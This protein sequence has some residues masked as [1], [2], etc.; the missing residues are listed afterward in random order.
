MLIIYFLILYIIYGALLVWRGFR[1][2]NIADVPLYVLEKPSAYKIILAILILPYSNFSYYIQSTVAQIKREKEQEKADYQ[3]HREREARE[4]AQALK[5]VKKIEFF[6]RN[7]KNTELLKAGGGHLGIK[8]GEIGSIL[9]YDKTIKI[10]IE[11]TGMKCVREEGAIYQVPCH[12]KGHLLC[13]NTDYKIIES[14]YGDAVFMSEDENS[15]GNLISC[16]NEFT[17]S[18]DEKNPDKLSLTIINNFKGIKIACDKISVIDFNEIK[19]DSNEKMEEYK[20]VINGS[21]YGKFFSIKKMTN[22]NFQPNYIKCPQCK[23]ILD[24]SFTAKSCSNPLCGFNFD[25]LDALLNKND[26]ELRKALLSHYK[27]R[28]G[29]VYKLITTAIR[30]NSGNYL[31]HFIEC[32]S[33]AHYNTLFNDFIRHFFDDLNILKAVLKSDVIKQRDNVIISKGGYK[34]FWELYD[35]LKKLNSV[36]IRNFLIS[37]FPDFHRR[38]YNDYFQKYEAGRKAKNKKH[39]LKHQEA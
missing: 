17:L 21:L 39:A 34:M 5:N 7:V 12:S 32:N 19:I 29:R 23:N 22:N 11:Q 35:R 15:Q 9:I 24:L 3:K 16:G 36:E 33:G 1:N 13:E 2:P 6:E 8:A 31:A 14:K 10:E 20:E 27:D 38:H 18:K 30:Y 25:G 4:E 37:E 28:E 26:D